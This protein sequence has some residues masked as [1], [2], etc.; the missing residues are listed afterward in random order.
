MSD[1]TIIFLQL[2]I[3]VAGAVVCLATGRAPRV[4]RVCGV[5]GSIAALMAAV[6]L[7]ARVDDAG[8]LAAQASGWAAPYGITLV[9][10]RLAAGIVLV[11]ALVGLATAVYGLRDVTDGRLPWTFYPLLHFLLLGVQ[12]AFLTGDLFNLYVW[13]EVMLV[14]SFVLLTLG[15]GRAQLEGA[16]KYV[17]LNILASALFLVGAGM[18]YGKLG[19]LNMA[20]IAIKL[21]DP[22]EVALL[23]TSGILLLAA[24]GLKAGIFPLFFWL[25]ASY[26]TPR[27]AVSAVFAGLLTKVGVYA[28]IRGYTLF[29]S[30]TF[31][32]LRSLLIW[33][34]VATMVVGV[35]GAAA[36]FEV[37]RILSFHIVSQIGYM[38]L[39][40]A[41]MTP[42][43]LA[44]A[45]FYIGHHII[46]KT[47]LFFV[48]GIIEEMRGSGELGRLGGLYRNH[49]WLAVLFFVPAFSLGGIP[50]LSG[51]WA[52]LAIVEA[53][54]EAEAWVATAFA[55]GVGILTL[56]SMTK[57]W[58]EAFW[59]ADPR[60]E[61]AAARTGARKPLAP[62]VL[63]AAAF[64][65]I[66]VV[67][68]LAGGEMFAYAMRAA[69]QLMDNAI[70]IRTVLGGLEGG[71]P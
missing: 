58:M 12:G 21:Q 29:L 18:L 41:L 44:G 4:Q 37:R 3:P 26:H 23:H 61:E 56:F 49:P 14:A 39:G 33:T 6:L 1:A 38:V 46:V 15:N 30:G 70:Y 31:E 24:F 62:L 69:D 47:N 10:D 55:L 8:V 16:L 57:I 32:D 52:K 68:G 28:L 63:P 54:L 66:T 9:A 59:K 13:F 50:P 22:S 17:V 42:L 2:V 51:F 45:V 40:L 71:V 64:A 27:V 35:L 34:A 36:H 19:T 5:L 43:A 53:G 25:P 7:V 65:T 60:G 11:A 48:G 67:I 20:D